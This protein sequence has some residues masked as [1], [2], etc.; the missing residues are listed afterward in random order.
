MTWIKDAVQKLTKR[1][2]T[3]DPFELA[4]LKNIHVA[5][6]DLHHEIQGFYKYDRRNMYIVINSNLNELSQ[7]YVCGHELGHSQLHPRVN[8]PFLRDKTFLSVDRMEVE[9]NTFAVELLLSDDAINEYKESGLSIEKIAA[10]HGVP[11]EV[12][13]LKSLRIVGD[14]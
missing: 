12:A 3:T 6:W 4:A 13:H 7:R 11:E 2:D 9:A 10:I 1:Y 8:T 5:Y 14:D